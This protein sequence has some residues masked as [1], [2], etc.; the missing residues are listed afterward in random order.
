MRRFDIIE[1][2]ADTGILAYGTSLNEAFANAAYGMF[3]MIADLEDV[4]E[5]VCR[6]IRVQAEDRESLLVCWL[7]ELLYLLDVERT[8]FKRFDVIQLGETDLEAEAYGEPI[9]ES[10]HHLRAGIK[11]ATYYLLKIEKDDGY[12]VQVIL[13]T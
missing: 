7:N 12:R 8:L 13:D 3:T 11:A 1:H 9:D 4:Q 5:D 6:R 10:R 2:T